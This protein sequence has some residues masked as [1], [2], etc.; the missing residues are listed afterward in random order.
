IG[1]QQSLMADF[2]ANS[3]PRSVLGA[4][5]S[6]KLQHYPEVQ[7]AAADG[8]WFEVHTENFCGIGGA[9]LEAL[10]VMA[11]K[12]PLSLHGVGAS[13]AGPDQLSK[14]HLLWV[15]NLVERIQPAL[16]SEHAVWSGIQEAYF[17]DLL[18]F[19]RTKFILQQLA[20]GIHRYQETIDRPLLIENPTH[21]V[22]FCHEMSEPDF[23]LT[24]AKTTGCG[25]LLDITNLYLSQINCGVN[26]RQYLDQIPP[27]LVG[28]LHVAGFSSDPI[29]GDRLLI[30][31]HD[32]A[33]NEEI[34]S[35][36]DYALARFGM[37]PVLLEW[38]DQIP[39]LNVLLQERERIQ[40]VLDR[41]LDSVDAAS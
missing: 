33:P 25:L 29:E 6:L 17:A 32:H 11:E 26:A 2:N 13:L 16:I 21:Y 12:F 18:P 23:M 28:E 38:D 39:E 35:L 15:Q 27:H 10:Q 22:N 31:S 9:R 14:Q 5:V 41:H 20:E 8:I 40:S 37:R 34:L 7:S 30:D 19:P 1:P 24:L 36:L 4:G 3:L